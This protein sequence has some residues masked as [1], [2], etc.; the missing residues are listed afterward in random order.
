MATN[1]SQLEKWLTAQK[2]HHLSDKQVQMARELAK[3]TVSL[4]KTLCFIIEN[5]LF[6]LTK[7]FVPL[8][9]NKLFFVVETK[10]FSMLEQTVQCCEL[11]D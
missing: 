2:R 7:Q 8:Y 10:C 6:S 11:T 1:R 3:Q 4:N 5:T 9:E